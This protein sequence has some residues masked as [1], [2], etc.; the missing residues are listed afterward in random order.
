MSGKE[1]YKGEA[2][3]VSGDEIWHAFSSRHVT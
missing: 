3:M 2:E 1:N